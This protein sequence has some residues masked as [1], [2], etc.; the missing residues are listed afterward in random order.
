MP[1]DS[2]FANVSLLLHFGGADASTTFTDSSGTPKTV[3]PFGNAKISTTQSKFGGS[4]GYFDG[5]G[6]RLKTTDAV[7]NE[8][9]NFTVECWAWFESGG[10]ASGALWRV[11]G[12]QNLEVYRVGTHMQLYVDPGGG[13]VIVGSGTIAYASA[14]YHVALCRVSGVVTL[15]LDGVSQ[16]AV[17]LSSTVNTTYFLIGAYNESGTEQHK[18]YIDELRITKGVARYTANFT[19]PTEA[20]PDF[21]GLIPVA[22]SIVIAGQT[23]TISQGHFLTPTQAALTIAGGQP[24]LSMF[25]FHG[26]PP[27]LALSIAGGDA[28]IAAGIAISA[29]QR[30]IAVAGQLPDGAFGYAGS[31][32]QGD[33]SIVGGQAYHSSETFHGS[34]AGAELTIDGL[35]AALAAGFIDT[36]APR[37]ISIAGQLAEFVNR[38]LSPVTPQAIRTLYRCYLTGTSDALPDLEI[39][40]E[41]F[42]TRYGVN[43]LRAYLAVVVNGIDAYIDAINARPNGRLRVDR[44]YHYIDGTIDTFVMAVTPLDTI[45]L[46]QGAR[47]GMTGTI[48]GFEN[49]TPITAQNIQLA[50]AT[51]YSLSGGKRRYRCGLDPRLRPLDTAIINGDTFVVG[52]ITHIVDARTTTMEIA[53]A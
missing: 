15:Y 9:G 10:D 23:P 32:V 11:A 49:M 4:S 17:S 7:L 34:P 1:G 31:S 33:L 8:T 22:G 21:A 3:T 40:I 42:Q 46:Y 38:I 29:V 27:A 35:Q 30:Q 6:D 25:A 19:P 16:G 26:A 41:S 47:A 52:S 24:A 51:Y 2:N 13:D 39:R 36:A 48:T 5:A 53:E 45:D 43:P 50:N 18:G 44:E 37:A 20:F 14:W 28:S 12:S